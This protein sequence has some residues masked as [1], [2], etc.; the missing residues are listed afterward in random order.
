MYQMKSNA[1]HKFS[2][3]FGCRVLR[4]SKRRRKGARHSCRFNADNFLMF[5]RGVAAAPPPPILDAPT[6]I[7]S[8]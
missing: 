1:P 2:R 6:S 5:A 7:V 8:L 4:E 3:I